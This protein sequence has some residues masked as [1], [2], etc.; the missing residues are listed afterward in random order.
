VTARV[1]RRSGS[2]MIEPREP[3]VAMPLPTD[4]ANA[5]RMHTCPKRIITVCE[6]ILNE[7]TKM[8]TFDSNIVT[9]AAIWL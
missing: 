4:A 3:S 1:G 7:G 6:R 5:L 9:S 2:V 8:F